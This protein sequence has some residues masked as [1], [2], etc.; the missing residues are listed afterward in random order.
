MEGEDSDRPKD[1]WIGL[2]TIWSGEKV[3]GPDV[4]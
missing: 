2:A 1:N 4:R 3:G